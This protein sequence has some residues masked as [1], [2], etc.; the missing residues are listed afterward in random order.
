[1]Y[2]FPVVDVLRVEPSADVIRRVNRDA[3]YDAAPRRDVVPPHRPDVL[4]RVYTAP[5]G[6]AIGQACCD[7]GNP[8]LHAWRVGTDD[9][10]VT[11]RAAGG[12]PVELTAVVR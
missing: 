3:R 11:W 12:W 7:C 2:W 4:R 8:Y 5:D 9:P 6:L 1:M 10:G